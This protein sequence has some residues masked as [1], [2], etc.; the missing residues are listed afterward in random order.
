M[1]PTRFLDGRL[2]ALLL[3]GGTLNGLTFR[4]VEVFKNDGVNAGFDFFGVSPFEI[5]IAGVAARLLWTAGPIS[6]RIGAAAVV[7]Y[8]LLMLWPSSLV[9]WMLV[10]GLALALTPGARGPARSGAALFAALGALEVWSA[11]IEPMASRSLLVLDARVVASVLSWVRDGIIHIGNVVGAV[12]GHRIVV[13]VGC[14]TA[15]FLPLALL[16]AAA[17]LLARDGRLSVW[18]YLGLAGL[19]VVLIATN[20]IRLSLMA[21]S[22]AFYHFVHGPTGSLVFDTFTC[23]LIVA[24]ALAI[25]QRSPEVAP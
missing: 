25:P 20:I 15:H 5:L 17:L 23:V 19:A 13:L 4:I 3:A 21:W 8:M 9:A 11:S 6:S 10:T 18:G 7:A 16:G 2:A 1:I 24:V 12:D 22:E 14:S